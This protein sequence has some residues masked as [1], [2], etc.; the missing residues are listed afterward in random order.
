MF[1]ETSDAV[2]IANLAVSGFTAF[3]GAAATVIVAYIAY[4]TVKLKASQDAAAIN[5]AKIAKAVAEVK[6]TAAE[7]AKDHGE[8]LEE[9]RADTVANSKDIKEVHR[10]I[11]SN[12]EKQM[13]QI[14][15]STQV[16][17]DAAFARGKEEK[18]AEDEDKPRAGG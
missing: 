14:A 8:K 10:T 15:E 17:V 2:Q 4:L 11:N 7:T 13:A 18:R 1:A 5:S 3:V 12:L 6:T 16:S 9:I